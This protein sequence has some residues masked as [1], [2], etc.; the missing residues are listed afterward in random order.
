MEPKSS[1]YFQHKLLS[2][3]F[4]RRLHCVSVLDISMTRL[5]HVTFKDTWTFIENL[6]VLL[7]LHKPQWKSC[8]DP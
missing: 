7:F 4:Y 2:M 3:N 1:S 5:S 8:S 6:I